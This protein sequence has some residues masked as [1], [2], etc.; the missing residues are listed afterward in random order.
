MS[1]R[2]EF[3]KGLGGATAGIFFVGCGLGDLAYG[4]PQSGSTGGRREIVIGG[5]RVRTID[6]H[7]HCYVHDV[8]PSASEWEWLICSFSR[9]ARKRQAFLPQPRNVGVNIEQF[10]IRASLTVIVCWNWLSSG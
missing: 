5:R 2:R 10:S 9:P 6:M 4:S 1:N 7:A 3:L 8:W